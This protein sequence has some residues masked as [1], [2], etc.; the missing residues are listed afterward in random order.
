[1][2]SQ[3]QKLCLW[4]GVV[5][6]VVFGLGWWL[7]AGFVPPP[8]PNA[9]AAQVAESY[10]TNTWMIRLGLL[11]A[12]VSCTFYYPWISAI[13]CQMKRI[14]GTT[15]IFSWT[16]LVSGATGTFIIYLPMFIWLV[17]SF[18]PERNPEL[19][20]LLNDFGWLLFTTTLA[21]FLAQNISIALAI[22]TDKSATPVFPRWLGFYNIAVT[23]LFLPVGLIFFFKAGP[24]AWNGMIGFWIPLLDFFIWMVVMTVFLFKAVNQ[25]KS[26][27]SVA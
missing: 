11:I 27:E 12:A 10:Q 5:F 2:N 13:S 6:M 22:L 14:E 3:N 18:R 4:S 1:M 8:D 26:L 24:F 20:L 7:I 23:T 9:T 15:P 21:P 17:A 19:I 25:E 16:Q